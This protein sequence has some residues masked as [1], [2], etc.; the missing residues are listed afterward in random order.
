M[1]RTITPTP[2]AEW[3]Q[4]ELLERKLGVRTLARKMN[5]DEPEVARRALNR[6]LFEGANPTEANR[7]LIAAALDVDPSEVPDARRASFH[8][9]ANGGA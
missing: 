3:L 4:A 1:G 8:A 6:Y 7:D 5:P 2:L 9:G